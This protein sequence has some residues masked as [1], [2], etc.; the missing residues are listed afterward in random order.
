[1]V[2]TRQHLATRSER[3]SSY[4]SERSL[5]SCLLRRGSRVGSGPPSKHPSKPPSRVQSQLALDALARFSPD[6]S[7]DLTRLTPTPPV[8]ANSTAAAAATAPLGIMGALNEAQQQQL[9]M[10]AQQAS[11]LAMPEAQPALS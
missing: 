10:Q 6:P 11:V 9:A 3:P 2:R 4:A 1:M 5:G 8:L 7:G